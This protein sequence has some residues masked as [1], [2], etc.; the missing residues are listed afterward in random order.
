M[1]AVNIKYW[2]DEL[3]DKRPQLSLEKIRQAINLAQLASEDYLRQGL[4]MAEILVELNVDEATLV[5][6][7]VC[8][9]V[10]HAGLDLEDISESLGARVGNLISHVKQMDGISGLAYAVS[11]HDDGHPKADNIRKMMLAIVN[12]IRAVLIKLAAQLVLLRGAKLLGDERKQRIGQE[13]MAIYAPLANRLGIGAMKWE[14]EDLAFRYIQPE[15]YKEISAALNQRRADREQYVKDLIKQLTTML[16]QAGLKAIEVTGRVKHIYSIYNKMQRKDVD[17]QELYDVTALRVLVPTVADCYTVLSNVHGA[18]EHIPE[19]FDDYIV[20]PKPNGYQS[21]HTAVIG[22]NGRSFEVQV[23]THTMHEEAEL[24]MAAHWVYKEGAQNADYEAKIAWLR[25]VMDWQQEVTQTDET[26]ELQE[27]FADRV[28]VFTP[29]GDIIDLAQGATALDFAYQVH[30]E[31][32]HRCRGAKVGGNIANLTHQLQTGDVVEILT[33]KEPRPSRDWMNPHFGFLHT[34]RA[35]AKVHSWFKKQDYDRHVEMGQELLEKE[36]KRLHLKNL[37][38]TDLAH[39]LK[40]K[41][42]EE[43]YVG[44]GSGYFKIGTV[45]NLLQREYKEL[46]PEP[47]PEIAVVPKSRGKVSA[48]IIEGVDN[49]LTNIAN[50]C[51]PVPGDEIIGYITQGKGVTIHRQDCFNMLRASAEKPER[52]LTVNWSDTLTN[53]PINLIIEAFDRYGLIKDITNVLTAEKVNLIGLNC[54]TKREE[55][56]AFISLTVEISNLALLEQIMTKLKQLT[57]VADVRRA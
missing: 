27:V 4:A 53:Y 35:R 43:L 55:G 41:T 19:E 26:S 37:N 15:T 42:P 1:L 54:G 22:K 52:L 40:Y 50:C 29:Q 32:G 18:W 46:E 24:G 17:F 21:I 57:D 7:I 28:Y 11:H 44:L 2:L 45:T 31:V 20:N 5:A 8:N 33:G 14:L 12:D 56:M 39:Q 49:L 47:E 48:I 38:L 34:S 3:A 36:I 25:Q 13:T 6:A 51:Q 30:S 10:L 9:A 16:H 23:R